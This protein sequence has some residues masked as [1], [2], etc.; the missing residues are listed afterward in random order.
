MPPVVVDTPRKAKLALRYVSAALVAMGAPPASFDA[1]EFLT[2]A[3]FCV[4]DEENEAV[5]SLSRDDIPLGEETWFTHTI[6]GPTSAWRG[7]MRTVRAH[8]DSI[9]KGSVPLLYPEREGAQRVAITRET[10]ILAT[11]VIEINGKRFRLH[12]AKSKEIRLRRRQT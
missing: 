10:E 1:E 7:L 9:G 8:F 2:E 5:I 12:R 3:H 4:I 11:T 6:G